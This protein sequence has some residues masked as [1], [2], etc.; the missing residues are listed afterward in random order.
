MEVVVI[1]NGIL[2]LTTAYRLRKLVPQSRITDRRSG[3]SSRLRISRR[4]RNV[5][6]FCRIDAGTL[7][8]KI[9]RQKFLFNKL[10]TPLWPSLLKEIE[11]ESGIKLG[12]GFGTFVI[13]N[14]ASDA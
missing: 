10:S 6:L 11:Y 14:H 13:N 1:G 8:N 3:K 5:Q 7:T 2:A 9:E 12:F 4:R